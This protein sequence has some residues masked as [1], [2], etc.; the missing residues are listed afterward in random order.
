MHW[1]EGLPAIPPKS[2]TGKAPTL[3]AANANWRKEAA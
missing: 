3:V 2:Q 1:L